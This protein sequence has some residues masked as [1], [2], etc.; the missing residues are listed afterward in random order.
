VKRTPIIGISPEAVDTLEPL[1]AE[2]CLVVK[3]PYCDAVRAA[4]GAA[5]VL[6]HDVEQL[7][8]TL[9]L[10][11]G[12]LIPGGPYQFPHR[13]LFDPESDAAEP[14]AKLG[15]ARFELE[16]TRAALERDLPLLGICGGQQILNAATGGTLVVDIEKECAGALSHLQGGARETVHPVRLQAG[17]QLRAI[18]GRDEQPVNSQHRQSVAEP[19]A[20][21]AVN[22]VAPDGVI[23]GIELPERR[24][25]IGVQWHPEYLLTE[26]DRRLLDAFVAAAAAASAHRLGT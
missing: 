8:A 6:P 4:G 17:T 26:G 9:A 23:E 1:T 16:L 7:G 19:G 15:R 25:C 18:V 24:F 14:A 21:V 20:G 2:S 12:V 22:A 5:V 11:D 13:H 10:V 3:R